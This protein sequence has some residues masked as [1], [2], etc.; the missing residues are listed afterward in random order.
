MNFDAS[1]MQREEEKPVTEDRE[2]TSGADREQT[3]EQTSSDVEAHSTIGQAGSGQVIS[4]TDDD[5]SDVEAHTMIGQTSSQTN[6]Q[7]NP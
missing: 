2:Q 7:T 1:G 5:E 3:S 4:Q 6:P